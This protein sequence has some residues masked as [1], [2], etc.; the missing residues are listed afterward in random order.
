VI[1]VLVVLQM[2]TALRPLIG[3][4]KNFLP[5]EKKSFIAHWGDNLSSTNNAWNATNSPPSGRD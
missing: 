2:T 3:T 1:F 4:S 5:K